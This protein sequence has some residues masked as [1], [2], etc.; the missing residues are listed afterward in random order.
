M[1]MYWHVP[2]PGPF[3]VGG[4][5]GGPRYKRPPRSRWQH[6]SYWITGLALMELSAWAFV[7]LTWLSVWMAWASVLILIALVRR[8]TKPLTRIPLLIPE[9]RPDGLH[10]HHQGV[11]A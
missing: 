2:L 3:S 6:M 10:L 4:P 1:R 11:S 9:R 7:G 8:S 5:I